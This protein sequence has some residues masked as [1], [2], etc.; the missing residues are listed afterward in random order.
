M[1]PREQLP[2]SPGEADRVFIKWRS[3]CLNTV[4]R[5]GKIAPSPNSESALDLF[6]DALLFALLLHVVVL[7]KL[8][9]MRAQAQ[10]VVV[11][12]PEVDQCVDEVLGEHVTL[13][14]EVVIRRERI[15]GTFE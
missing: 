7:V 4:V 11:L 9:R 15:G 6:A 3:H 14:Q 5:R 13:Q 1:A 2:T 10:V 8:E 12:D